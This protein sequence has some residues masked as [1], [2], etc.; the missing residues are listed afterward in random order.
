MDFIK[1]INLTNSNQ[2]AVHVI[3]IYLE[4]INPE[5]MKVASQIFYFLSRKRVEYKSIFIKKKICFH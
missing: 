4:K 5:R 3:N 2:T 1:N